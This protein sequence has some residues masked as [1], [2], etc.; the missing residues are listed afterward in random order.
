MNQYIST[1]LRGCRCVEIDCWDEGDEV[2]VYHGHTMTSKIKLVHVLT[3][4]KV[5]GFLASP[6]PIVLSLE[7]HCCDR[8][9]VQVARHFN[10][11]HFYQW[12]F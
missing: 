12:C 9:K 11:A 2:I 8:G 6:Y 7:M 10:V 1:L 5:Y 3:A 4:I